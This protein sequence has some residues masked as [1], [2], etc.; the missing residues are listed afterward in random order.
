MPIQ[1]IT[2]A[3]RSCGASVLS[4]GLRVYLPALNFQGPA[5]VYAANNR[6]RTI[7]LSPLAWLS[8][9][10]LRAQRAS[11]YRATISE[12]RE[13]V[14]SQKSP[15]EWKTPL[16][17]ASPH[18]VLRY[19]AGPRQ[20]ICYVGLE[21]VENLESRGISHVLQ[22]SGNSCGILLGFGELFSKIPFLLESV[23]NLE[24]R[25]ISH[26]LQKSGNSCGI[27]LGFGELFSKIPFLVMLLLDCKPPGQEL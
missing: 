19:A 2:L 24:S 8:R 1:P 10:P 5:A 27:L 7:P 4:M 3:N 21:S 14:S 17:C 12:I 13:R 22:K 16:T 25:G 6:P 15:R 23:E 11:V 26:V 20:F 18:H 9:R